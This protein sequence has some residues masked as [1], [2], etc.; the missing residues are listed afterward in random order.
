MIA[1]TIKVGDRLSSSDG[2]FG[3]GDACVGCAVGIDGCAHGTAVGGYVNWCRPKVNVLRVGS[4]GGGSE[5]EHGSGGRA[6]GM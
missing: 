1:S 5:M 6:G 2:E 3:C 4:A